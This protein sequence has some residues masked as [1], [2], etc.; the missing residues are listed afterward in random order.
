MILFNTSER[1][2]NYI[3]Y[4]LI[5][6]LCKGKKILENIRYSYNYIILI[7]VYDNVYIR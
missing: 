4:E 1:K 7:K 3:N 2:I 6:G 5:N